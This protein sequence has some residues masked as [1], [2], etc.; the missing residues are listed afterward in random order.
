[1]RQWSDNPSLG[2]DIGTLLLVLWIPVIGNV[3]A[4]V[5]NLLWPQPARDFPPGSAFVGHLLVKLTPIA[6]HLRA[7]AGPLSPDE[8][9]FA[10][11]LGK[12]G[13][14]ARL[15]LPLVVW[16]AQGETQ[17]VELELLRPALALPR[18]P[19]TA[20]FRVLAGQSFVGDGRVVEVLGARPSPA[21]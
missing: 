13:F 6:P 18:L 21:G 11:V 15:P 12:E 7:P 10:L 19:A 5:R 16:L 2:R 1:M 20:A 14:S 3:V 8:H 4:F 9:G 17:T